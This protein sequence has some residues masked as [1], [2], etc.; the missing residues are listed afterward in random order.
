MIGVLGGTWGLLHTAHRGAGVRQGV[1][2][3]AVQRGRPGDG[4]NKVEA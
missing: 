4:V 1:R 2:V 3:K